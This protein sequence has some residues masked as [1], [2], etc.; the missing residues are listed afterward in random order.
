MATGAFI[1]RHMIAVSIIV[2]GLE[3]KAQRFQADGQLVYSLLDPNQSVL[4]VLH[5]NFSISRDGCKWL[6]RTS[7]ANDTDNPSEIYLYDEAGCDGT[8]IYTYSFTNPAKRTPPPNPKGEALYGSGFVQD[9]IVP[10]PDDTFICSVWLVYSSSCYLTTS[11]E[12]RIK[13]VIF[14]T[15]EQFDAPEF[16]ERAEWSF[17]DSSSTFL[18]QI[19]YL[20]DNTYRYQ[21]RAGVKHA[22]PY[23]APINNGYTNV[24]LSIL[25]FT[26][27]GDL[28][29]P[30]SFQ[31]IM[32]G[33]D[34]QSE[35][36]ANVFKRVN[37]VG[38]ITNIALSAPESYLPVITT[39]AGI[40]DMRFAK[41][42]GYQLQYTSTNWYSK[43]DP[44]LIK[45]N[46][47]FVKGN[48]QLV[49]NHSPRGM[50][51]VQRRSVIIA[52]IIL[53]TFPLIWLLTHKTKTKQT[54]K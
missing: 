22:I 42:G 35:T 14:T 15:R 41:T 33:V 5:K 36:K 16:L 46:D 13:P 2:V 24:L 44:R 54:D 40:I 51:I 31:F 27:C 49:G 20:S 9:G 30:M 26:N 23:P 53:A 18:N 48:P 52:L 1:C 29:V 6:I 25:S 4:Y 3:L 8:N 7:N 17:S 45:K 47:T 37:I 12:K 34:F 32:N 38:S 28:R 39:K 19:I 21:D 50:T 43:N 11:V 10:F